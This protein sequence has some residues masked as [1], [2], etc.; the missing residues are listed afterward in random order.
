MPDLTLT[1]DN[2]PNP[3][4]TPGVLDALSRRDILATFF[5][6]GRNLE[7]PAARAIMERAHACNHWIGNH[8]WTHAEP[9]G[10]R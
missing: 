4:V 8:T 7:D 10:R 2:G 9:L 1:F 6:I 3:E 5:V